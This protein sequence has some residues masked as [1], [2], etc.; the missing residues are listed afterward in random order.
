MCA[1]VGSVIVAFLLILF[2]GAFPVSSAST[3]AKE[4]AVGA[5]RRGGSYDDLVAMFEEFREF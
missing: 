2:L 4:A 1:R 5:A 3:A